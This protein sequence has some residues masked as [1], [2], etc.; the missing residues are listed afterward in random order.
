[1]N[2]QIFTLGE[3]RIIV[4]NVDIIQKLK[5]SPK[6]IMLLEY[7]L[8]NNGK[9][10][11]T[12]NIIDALWYGRDDFGLEN[13]LKTLVSRLR[14]D[15]NDAGLPN[16]IITKRGAYMWNPE[17]ECDI[18]IVTFE[19]LATELSEV[20]VLDENNV[21]LFDEVLYI[22]SDDLLVSSSL[23]N[24]F[25]PKN[26]YYHTL[27]LKTVTRYINLLNVKELYGDVIRVCKTALEIDMFDTL[28]NLELMRAL[29]KLGKNK[30]ALERYQNVTD[31]HYNHL[32]IKPSEEILDFYKLLIMEEQNTESNIEDIYNELRNDEDD[33][34]AFV[35][36][37]AIFKDIYRLY[38]RNLKRLGSNMHL[39]IVTI[40]GS[41]N[42]EIDPILVDKTMRRL[43]NLLQTNLRSGDTIARYSPNQFVILLPN[44]DNSEMGKLVL[45]R[46][47]G[48]FFS[49]S[50]NTKFSFDFKLL[51]VFGTDDKL[52]ILK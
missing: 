11:T 15:L 21:D 39:A 37:Y 36:E 23:S 33:R 14:K 1:M 13:T 16:A 40:H 48:K 26:Y 30:E 45:K 9:A 3:L 50:A 34:D 29:L 38:M 6:K 2:V 12:A 52:A 44:I 4:N 32:G 51:E 8:V 35:C 22:Y 28:L 7:L 31:L 10:A 20:E 18:D 41:S 27:Y 49:D 5:Q 25:S 46:L 24:W 43:R 19:K 17:I 47:Q 42:V